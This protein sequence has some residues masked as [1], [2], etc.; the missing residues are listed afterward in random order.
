MNNDPVNIFF[1][2][3]LNQVVI[4]L[5][6][7]F[8]DVKQMTPYCKH[9]VFFVSVMLSFLVGSAQKRKSISPDVMSFKTN[10]QIDGNLSEWGDS[11]RYFF[12]K[13]DLQYEIAQ[14]N[15]HIYIAMRVKDGSWQMQA[16]HQGF[17]FVI[18]AEGK[19]KDGATIVF[20]V[21]DRESLRALAR[22][23]E[24]E[25]NADIR[26]GVLGTVRGIYVKGMTDVVDGL[27]SLENNY[28]IKTAVT[29]DSSD[30]VCYEAVI[31]FERISPSLFTSQTLA[32]NIKING[33]IM[34]TVGGGR[35][36]NRYGYG[37]FGNPYGYYGS[38]P[39]RREAHQ[40][41]GV[42]F[43]LPLIKK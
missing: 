23:D 24:E 28:G 37:G 9:I 34:K 11:L 15:G 29:I 5:S 26:R 25:K 33:I 8:N 39:T 36:M 10:I 14:D 17:N 43:L 13:Q 38:Q 1:M 2:L 20:P 7:D 22:K 30:A 31:P 21:P 27:I 40:E 42:W 3:Q 16:L 32:F 18:N 12:D 19:K 4:G 35:S 6:K 41:P